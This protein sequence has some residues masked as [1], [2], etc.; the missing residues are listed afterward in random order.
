M[1]YKETNL[2]PEAVTSLPPKAMQPLMSGSKQKGTIF[3]VKQKPNQPKI[4]PLAKFQEKEDT[5]IYCSP[6]DVCIFSF[7]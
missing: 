3:C 7:E 1:E 6:M 4:K 5:N 2:K